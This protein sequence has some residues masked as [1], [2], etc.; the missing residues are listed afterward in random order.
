[1]DEIPEYVR[2]ERCEGCAFSPGTKA[3][4]SFMTRYKATLCVLS[5]EPFLCHHN[6]DANE[7]PVDGTPLALCRG[8][9]DAFQERMD[10]GK[11]TPE[12]KRSV[13]LA[14]TQAI[15]DIE[16]NPELH[17]DGDAQVALV[18]AAVAKAIQELP[19]QSKC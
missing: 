1:M 13:Y 10:H 12:W 2:H 8:F 17:H 11:E 6:L 3:N 15:C 14:I 7:Q 19:S 18:N 5:G 16:Q 9:V 4:N